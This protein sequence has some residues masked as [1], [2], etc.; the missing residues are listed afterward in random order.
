LKTVAEHFPTFVHFRSR[1]CA[2]ILHFRSRVSAV[3]YRRIA[4]RCL[5]FLAVVTVVGATVAIFRRHLALRQ[6]AAYHEKIE[7]LVTASVGEPALAARWLK[8]A[9]QV[10]ANA[11]IR[12]RH[13]RLKEKYRRAARYPWLPVGPDPPE[14]E[15]PFSLEDLHNVDLPGL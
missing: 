10:R 14:P 15:K 9:P 5:V 7:N 4:R 8:A 3:N 2:V 6:R 13:A 1:L 11:A 12:D